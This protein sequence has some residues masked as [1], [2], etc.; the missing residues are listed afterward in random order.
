M[1]VGTDHHPYH[2]MLE[3]GALVARELDLDLFIQRG[4][5]PGRSDV[6]TIDYLDG[7]DLADQMR[8]ADAVVCHG[9]PGTISL[10]VQCGHRPI[11]MPRDPERGEHIDDHQMRYTAKLER[12]GSIDV[13]HTV[14]DLARLPAEP[15][16]RLEEV[17]DTTPS[18]AIEHFADLT[19]R[20]LAGTLPR[21]RWRNRVLWSRS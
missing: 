7:L 21:R 12:E 2:R 15:R 10:A 5:T 18:E 6:E 17:D 14:N 3:W 19:D 4:A 1:S 16:E 20:L 9:G 11:V 13:A 8:K